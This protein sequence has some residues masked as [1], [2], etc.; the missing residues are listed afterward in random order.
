MLTLAFYKSKYGNWQDKLVSII[1]YSKYSHVELIFS[2]GM[3]FS[4]SPRDGGVRYKQI[5]AKDDHWDYITL[6]KISDKEEDIIRKWCD[7]KLNSPYD[8]MGIVG[9]LLPIIRECHW[10]WFCSEICVWALR[11]TQWF[12]SPL[13]SLTNYKPPKVSPGKLWRILN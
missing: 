3:W 7:S 1:T 4:S 11:Q 6:P 5:L 8:W 13:I 9:L 2:D 10:K 12:H